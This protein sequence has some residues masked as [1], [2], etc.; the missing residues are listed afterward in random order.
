MWATFKMVAVFVV[1]GIPAG[2]VGMPWTLLSRRIRWMYRAGAW[3]ANAGLRASGIRIVQT[4][5]EHIPADR[6]CIYMANHVSNLDPPLLIPLLPGTPSVMLKSELM[7]IPVLGPA[8]RMARFVPVERDG[9]RAGAVRSAKVAVEVV[10]SGLSMLIFAEG[11]RSRD[12]RLQPFKA[13]PFHLSQ[14]TGAPIVPVVLHGTQ[15]MMRKGSARVYPGVAHV[16]FLPAIDPAQFATRAQ[17][18]AAV[19]SAMVD[20]LPEDMRPL[21]AA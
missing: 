2:F 20:A 12:G 10:A 21:D 16:Q 11:T 1:L 7:K 15:R 4:G 6:A 18:M 14:S 5:R 13:G 9:G 8:M 17:L 3:I 19:R